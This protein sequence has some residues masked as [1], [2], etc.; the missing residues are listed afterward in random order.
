MAKPELEFTDYTKFEQKP[1]TNVKGLS[2]RVIAKDPE[3]G[4][5]TRILIFEPGTDTTPNG[6]QIHDFW[7]ELYVIEGSLIDL[8]LNQEFTAG[9]VACRPPG[10]KHGPWISP[11]G[12][13]TFEVR[14]YSK[15][16]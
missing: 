13:K 6:V 16:Q 1:F 12:C 8:T 11:N 9:M 7:E 4:V 3:T 14:Y 15:G 10:M 5:A 2:E